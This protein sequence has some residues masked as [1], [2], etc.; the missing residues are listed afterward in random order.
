MFTSF[1]VSSYFKNV[2]E[3]SS[4]EGFSCEV[5]LSGF[6]AIICVSENAHDAMQCVH[7]NIFG[8]NVYILHRMV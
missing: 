6:L 3:A 4:C 7:Q 8:S 2:R 1:Q 5:F